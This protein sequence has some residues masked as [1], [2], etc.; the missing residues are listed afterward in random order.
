MNRL[1]REF[2]AGIEIV[3]ASLPIAARALSECDVF[4]GNDAGLAHLAA[5]LGVKTIALFG[6]TNPARAI[7]IGPAVALR[8][9]SCPPCHDEGMRDFRCTLNIN[10]RCMNQD[11]PV[12]VVLK[13]IEDALA[14][15]VSG[16]D[17]QRTS[18]FQLY[19]RKI[20]NAL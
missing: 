6:M 2:G 7:P 16:S 11:F 12:A 1:E 15:G 19:G 20:E 18:A 17:V 4:V 3:R 14:C 5:G 9:S 10:Y 13:A 8:P